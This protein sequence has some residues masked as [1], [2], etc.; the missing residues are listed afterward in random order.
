[1]TRTEV[2]DDL[3]SRRVPESL[4]RFTVSIHLP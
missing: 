4:E 2:L 1:L 3:T